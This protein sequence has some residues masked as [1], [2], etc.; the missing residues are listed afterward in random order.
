MLSFILL[1]FGVQLCGFAC[2]REMTEVER[3]KDRIRPKGVV[4]FSLRYLI[5]CDLTVKNRVVIKTVKIY[6]STQSH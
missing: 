2:E 1:L 5:F 6:N 4:C 3:D